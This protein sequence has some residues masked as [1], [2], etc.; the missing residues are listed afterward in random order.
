MKI[1]I[2]HISNFINSSPERFFYFLF[3]VF[4]AA[5]GIIITIGRDWTLPQLMAIGMICFWALKLLISSQENEIKVIPFPFFLLA[6]WLIFLATSI[7]GAPPEPYSPFS[8]EFLQSYKMIG[9]MYYFWI[10]LDIIMMWFVYNTLKDGKILIK[11]FKLLI[12]SSVIYSVYGIYQ[13]IMASLFG[14]SSNSVV[15]A[16]NY[17]Y[18]YD[19]Y[20]VR[21][22]SLSREPLYFANFICPVLIISIALL[23]TKSFKVVGFSKKSLLVITG[24]NLVAFFLAKSTGGFIAMTG[25]LMVI[26]LYYYKDY[27]YR[28]S[29]K[30][31][32]YGLSGILV[33][34]VSFYQLFGSEV[35]RRILGLADPASGYGRIVSILEAIGSFDSYPFFGFGL[36]HAKFFISITQIHNAYLN[37]LAETGIFSFLFFISF[38]AFL[39]FQLNKT[40]HKAGIYKGLVLGI[41]GAFIYI[42]I[43]WL[44]FFAYIVL[45]AWFLFGVILALPQSIHSLQNKRVKIIPV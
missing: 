17:H 15:Y 8:L 24:I 34:I 12:Y 18:L 39:A 27:T 9:V 44:S 10:V 33:F 14:A 16:L 32:A 28:I 22:L 5:N 4:I 20:I 19:D 31:I 29:Y 2:N 3:V 21:L 42:L 13:Y 26:L 38:L 11:T 37:I 1:K 25:S 43:Q 45:F 40:Y 23:V 6:I 7:I 41:A 35:E 36:G 30:K